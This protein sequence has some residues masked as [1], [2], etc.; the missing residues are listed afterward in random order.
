M[1]SMQRVYRL[2]SVRLWTGSRALSMLASTAFLTGTMAA[3]LIVHIFEGRLVDDVLWFAYLL[4]FGPLFLDAVQAQELARLGHR[5]IAAVFTIMR[6]PVY[7]TVMHFIGRVNV[8]TLVAVMVAA[9]AG[10]VFVRLSFFG[11]RTT[12]FTT[13]L[14]SARRRRLVPAGRGGGRS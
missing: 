14:E 8:V 2:R 10:D 6:I 3:V 5:A 9:L 4:F 11:E 12:S 13:E 1:V 7:L